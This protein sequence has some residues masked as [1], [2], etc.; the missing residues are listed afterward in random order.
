MNANVLSFL[1][2]VLYCRI[3][4][5]DD[6]D[7]LFLCSN[8]RGTDDNDKRE[9]KT[10]KNEKRRRNCEKIRANYYEE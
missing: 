7:V 2:R 8:L 6:D 9:G 4:G 1:Y 5:V 3:S 10:Y